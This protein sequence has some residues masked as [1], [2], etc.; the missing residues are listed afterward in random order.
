M[1]PSFPLQLVGLSRTIGN[2]AKNHTIGSMFPLKWYSLHEVIQRMPPEFIAENSYGKW[3]DVWSF[4]VTLF[5]IIEQE[6]PYKGR[7]E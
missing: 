2:A 7:N 4:G 6:E 3:T 1:S 5:E